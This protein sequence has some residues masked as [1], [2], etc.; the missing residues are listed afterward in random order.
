MLQ[1]VQRSIRFLRSLPKTV[2]FNLHYFSFNTA[3]KFPVFVDYKVR[4]MLCK[5]HVQIPAN[6]S[7]FMVKLGGSDMVIV[8]K[9]Y[10]RTVWKV[11]G[12][13]IFK[14]DC[15][16]THSCKISVE[17]DAELIFGDKVFLS[18]NVILVCTKKID[19]GFAARI[20]W[21]STLMDSDFHDIIEEDTGR[22]I[23]PDKAIVIGDYV[24]VGHTCV[25][26]KGVTVNDWN[27]I[28]SNSVVVKDISG[29]KQIWGGSPAKLIRE[30]CY[31]PSMLKANGIEVEY[32]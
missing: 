19:I 14:G 31:R 30:G 2:Y 11:E 22:I 32:R 16:I 4:L 24:W 7:K 6:P 26:K 20:G 21:F 10:N 5:G 3:V 28:G 15:K 23:N 17:K 1:K 25:I 13:V 29:Q 8:D 18:A 12:T 27:I 9:R